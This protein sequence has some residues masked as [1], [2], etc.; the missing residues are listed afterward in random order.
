ML[1]NNREYAGRLLAQEL[2]SRNLKPDIV[3]GLARGGVAVA[4]EIATAFS[5]PLEVLIVRKISPP[6]EPEF[7]VGALAAVPD[8]KNNLCFSVWWDEETIKRLRLSDEWKREQE[9]LTRSE[10]EEYRRNLDIKVQRTRSRFVKFNT[11]LLA[12]DGAATGATMMAAIKAIREVYKG[13]ALPRQG[14]ALLKLIAALPIAS[15]DATAKIQSQADETVILD[16]DPDF[17][18]VGQYYREFNQVGWDEVKT[19]LQLNRETCRQT[20]PPKTPPEHD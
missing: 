14:R 13:P 18:A 7:A 3:F 1:F 9:K 4:A 11:I 16:I 15:P 2:K 8:A 5:V 12:D 6:L 19:L 17:R 20:H 10:I